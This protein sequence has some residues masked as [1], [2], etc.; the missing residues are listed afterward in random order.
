MVLDFIF[1]EFTRTAAGSPTFSLVFRSEC[2]NWQIDER[3]MWFK[4]N[5]KI[6]PIVDIE[7]TVFQ[8]I[9]LT[10]LSNVLRRVYASLNAEPAKDR[11]SES[12]TNE[13]SEKDNCW[14]RVDY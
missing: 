12:S 10:N 13:H 4:S 3:R 9:F 7:I 8:N 1:S 14:S 6:K 2:S 5:N 11:Y